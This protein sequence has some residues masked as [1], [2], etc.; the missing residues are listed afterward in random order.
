MG[1][2]CLV[3]DGIYVCISST[4]LHC[5]FSFTLKDGV[6]VCRAQPLKGF[7]KVRKSLKVMSDRDGVRGRRWNLRVPALSAS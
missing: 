5:T 2:E 6:F 7:E 1:M 4:F 3:E